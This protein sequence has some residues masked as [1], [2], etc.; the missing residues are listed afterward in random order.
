MTVSAENFTTTNSNEAVRCEPEMQIGPRLSI[1]PINLA[2]EDV[3]VRTTFA[4]LRRWILARKRLTLGNQSRDH[5]EKVRASPDSIS[6]IF[7]YPGIDYTFALHFARACG[8]SSSRQA[9]FPP[10]D[11]AFVDSAVA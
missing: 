5:G 11:R 9:V 6:Y 10:R 1:I 4:R 2:N 8:I 7:I 3:P